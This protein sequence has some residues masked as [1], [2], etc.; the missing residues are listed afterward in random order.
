MRRPLINCLAGLAF[1]VGA[2]AAHAN[3]SADKWLE[4][5]DSQWRQG[6]TDQAMKSYEAAEKSEPNSSRILMK[7]AGLYLATQNFDSAIRTYQSVIGAEPGNAVAFIGMGIAY[8]HGGDNDLARAA[9]EEALR[10][11]PKRKAQLAPVLASLDE[12]A[13]RRVSPH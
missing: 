6:H 7:K 4:Q 11:E 12:Q 10:L 13:N 2:A 9:F 1:M 8:L 3:A 5:G